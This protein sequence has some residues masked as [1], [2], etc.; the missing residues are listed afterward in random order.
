MSDRVVIDLVVAR[1][2]ADI[3]VGHYRRAG[4]PL[5]ARMLAYLDALARGFADETCSEA[6]ESQSE[7]DI[8]VRETSKQLG[9]SEQYVRRIHSDLDGRRCPCGR[10]WVF[11][12]RS[13]IAY[14]EARRGA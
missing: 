1:H 11:P 7:H 4:R 9:C 10:G 12:R 2:F 13:V 14:A 5:D 6:D 3:A 8:G